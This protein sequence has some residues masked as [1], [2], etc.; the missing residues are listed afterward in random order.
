MD[1]LDL[2]QLDHLD[3]TLS[4]GESIL[5]DISVNGTIEHQALFDNKHIEDTLIQH[6]LNNL[7]SI[8]ISLL[9]KRF[10]NVSIYFC[11]LN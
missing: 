4:G 2:D 1:E 10:T 3:L 11:L 9:R 8:L 6:S 5:F 7:S